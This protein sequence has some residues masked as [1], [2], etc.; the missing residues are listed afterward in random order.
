[1]APRRPITKVAV[2]I[3]ASVVMVPGIGL[4]AGFAHMAPE[5][6]RLAFLSQSGAIVTGVLDW[7]AGRDIGFS[8]MVSMGAMA[9]VEVDIA[10]RWRWLDGYAAGRRRAGGASGAWRSHA[11]VRALLAAAAAAAVSR[12]RSLTDRRAAV[13]ALAHADFERARGALAGLLV[14][15]WDRD[16]LHD[17]FL[18]EATT[19]AAGRYEIRFTD[20]FFADLFEQSPDLYVRVFDGAGE[21]ELCSTR[22]SVRWNAGAVERLDVEVPAAALPDE[23][24]IRRDLA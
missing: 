2:S 8:H 17:D 13:A 4:N 7:A 23:S 19:D 11:A 24:G 21:R 18:G 16:L 5:P 14:R 12:E 10:S 3:G 9:D 1:M 6:G 20:E 15:A 22:D